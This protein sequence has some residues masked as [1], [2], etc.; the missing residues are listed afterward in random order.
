MT[1]E[2]ATCSICAA[3]FSDDAQGR[4]WHQLADLLERVTDEV[5]Q[6]MRGDG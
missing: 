5:A 1:T 4:R 2:V 6:R 3:T